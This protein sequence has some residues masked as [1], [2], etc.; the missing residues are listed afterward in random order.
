MGLGLVC[1]D[2]TL[3]VVIGCVGLVC[4]IILHRIGG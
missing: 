2:T 3:E 4:V 1:V